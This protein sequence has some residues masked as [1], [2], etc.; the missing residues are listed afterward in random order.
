LNKHVYVSAFAAICFG[1]VS[2]PSTADVSHNYNEI[3]TQTISNH[4]TG[5]LIKNITR[6][7]RL[8]GI[9]II[10]TR[11]ELNPEKRKFAFSATQLKDILYKAGFRGEALK[12][13]WAVAM[14]ESTGKPYALNSSS[15]CYGLFQ[16]N[17][18]GSMGPDR[19]EKYGL[20]SNREL[21]DPLTN[22]KIAY[23]M[24]NSGKDWSAWSTKKLALSI[25]KQ[26]PG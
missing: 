21:F 15:N 25:I 10:E 11:P 8:N 4:S 5:D 26:F 18:T 2:L 14:Q 20:S 23:Q 19:R 16:I 13:A 1:T 7:D 24:S 22:A 12:M 9:K 6:F 3:V 17:M